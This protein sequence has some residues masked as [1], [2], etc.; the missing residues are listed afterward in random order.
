[1][2]IKKNTPY[3]GELFDDGF[4]RDFLILSV[5]E[6][7]QGGNHILA[8]FDG[9][10]DHSS[11]VELDEATDDYNLYSVLDT[12]GEP[13]LTFK[14]SRITRNSQVLKKLGLNGKKMGSDSEAEAFVE[15]ALS[16][17]STPDW[18]GK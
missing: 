5:Q 2:D 17:S 7:H 1:M 13:T 11:T 14:I 4:H 10:K 12:E 6:R 8:W 9:S 3:E 15:L 18:T 16:T